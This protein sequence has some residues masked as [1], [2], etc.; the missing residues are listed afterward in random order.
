MIT[1][2]TQVELQSGSDIQVYW[3][4][5]DLYEQVLKAG[6]QV[7]LGESDKYWVVR[8]ACV[9]VSSDAHLPPHARVGTIDYLY[10]PEK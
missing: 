7:R 5:H 6:S 2:V 10:N 9:T 8:T 3:L 1:R 4:K